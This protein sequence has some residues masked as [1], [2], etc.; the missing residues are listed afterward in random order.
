M[1][2]IYTPL[3]VIWYSSFICCFVY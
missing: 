1:Y 2:N 3:Y